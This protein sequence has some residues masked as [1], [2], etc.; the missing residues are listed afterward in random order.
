MALVGNRHRIT[1][2]VLVSA[3]LLLQSK[4]KMDRDLVTMRRLVVHLGMELCVHNPSSEMYMVVTHLRKD[5]LCRCMTLER[6]IKEQERKVEEEDNDQ[7]TGY[8]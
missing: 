2:A 4:T 6:C 7:P 5:A 1:V 8:V 3:F